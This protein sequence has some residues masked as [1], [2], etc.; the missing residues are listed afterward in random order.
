MIVIVLFMMKLFQSKN[1]FT[2]LINFINI[3][4][5][6]IALY[7]YIHIGGMILILLIQ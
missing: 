3:Y 4:P 2:A 5:I 7:T 6:G 1:H